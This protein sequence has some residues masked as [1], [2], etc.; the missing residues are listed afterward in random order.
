MK[1]GFALFLAFSMMLC[2]AA[3]GSNSASPTASDSDSE[4]NSLTALSDAANCALI[5]PKDV[6]ISNESF[7]LLEGDPQIAEYQFTSDGKA[8]QLRFANVGIDTDICGVEGSNGTL[9][10]DS[11]AEAHY[12]EN[13]TMKVYRWF[14]VDGQ[15]VFQ[16]TDNSEWDW[17]QF[18]AICS[19]FTKM[20]PKNW[21]SDVPF[22]DYQALEGSYHDRKSNIAS[23][24][25]H[26]DHVLVCVYLNP[27]DSSILGWEMEA[28]LDGDRLVYDK[29]RIAKT[30]YDE[31]AGQ[32]VETPLED[33][34]AGYIQ[35]KDG[36]LFFSGAYSEALKDLVFTPF[37]DDDNM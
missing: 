2:C 34:G 12:I 18:D 30:V 33:G 27:D 17:A 1:K 23:I 36:K 11:K 29:E 14:T 9:F 13:D 3:C 20:E 26:Q 21:S 15:Y 10:A 37:S 32:T 8:C 35:L 22:A 16:V 4:I 19:Q 28:V 31:S 24:T 7:A 6:K 25:I 5:K